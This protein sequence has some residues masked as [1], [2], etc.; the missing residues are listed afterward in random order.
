[1]KKM[2]NEMKDDLLLIIWLI[3]ACMAIFFSRRE[4]VKAEICYSNSEN[5]NWDQFNLVRKLSVEKIRSYKGLENLSE[6][7]ALQAIDALYQLSII[8]YNSI[9]NQGSISVDTEGIR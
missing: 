5:S 7:K 6:E 8:S 3:F 9:K 2:T 1:M 4:K